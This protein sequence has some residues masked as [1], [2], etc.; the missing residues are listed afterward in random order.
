MWWRATK[1]TLVGLS[2]AETEADAAVATCKGAVFVVGLARQMMIP[3]R[4]WTA[5][6][7]APRIAVFIDNQ[8]AIQIMSKQSRG[9]NRHMDIRLKFLQLG[10][11]TE[12]FVFTYIP[13][14]D[15]DADIGTKVLALP[16]FRKLRARILGIRADTEVLQDI[17]A[18]ACVSRTASPKPR[19]KTSPS[20][21][22]KISPM[23][24]RGRCRK[25][26]ARPRRAGGVSE[27]NNTLTSH[28]SPSS[29][30]DAI[31][32]IAERIVAKAAEQATRVI[33]MEADRTKK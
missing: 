11:S 24:N 25:L 29:V 7:P 22:R 19:R 33:D 16:A 3:P 14:A 27:H 8:A 9:R 18:M 1:A 31:D 2:T 10:M 20:L 28:C 17:V 30:A 32:H 15:N 4:Q 5:H 13:S 26:D 21:N 6:H 23:T 12:Q